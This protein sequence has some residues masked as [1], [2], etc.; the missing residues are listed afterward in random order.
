MLHNYH[1]SFPIRV[2][3]SEIDGQKIVFNAHYSTYIDI[4]TTEYFRHVL[5]DRLQK[6]AE[7]RL[8]DPVLRKITIEFIKPAKL[9]DLLDVYCRI[10]KIGQSSFQL[11]HT[12]T[13]NEETLVKAEVIQVNFNSTTGHAKAIPQEIK[14]AIIIFEKLSDH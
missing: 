4:A 2:R 13:R 7:D 14:Q 8:F 10:T 1:F 11:E 6:L 3:Y 5:G 12:I 9:D